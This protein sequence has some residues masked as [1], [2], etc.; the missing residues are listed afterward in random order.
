MIGFAIFCAFL[1]FALFEAG[2]FITQAPARGANILFAL[3]LGTAAAAFFVA[4][5]VH[6]G[7]HIAKCKIVSLRMVIAIV[8]TY[9]AITATI[10]FARI[11]THA[12]LIDMDQG[13]ASGGDMPGLTALLAAFNLFVLPAVVAYALGRIFGGN[14]RVA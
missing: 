2:V 4:L 6:G 13:Q 11:P 10:S 14:Q 9:L 12:V 5:S 7:I 1:L 3:V 8:V